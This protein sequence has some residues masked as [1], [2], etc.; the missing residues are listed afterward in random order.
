MLLNQD[1][2]HTLLLEDNSKINVKVLYDDV[3]GM[4]I[5]K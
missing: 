2:K 1:G 3:F 5:S 4:I